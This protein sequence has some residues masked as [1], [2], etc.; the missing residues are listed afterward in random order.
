MKPKTFN[1]KLMINKET[2]SNLDDRSMNAVLG[3]NKTGLTCP[4]KGCTLSCEDTCI[5]CQNTC[6]VTIC[7][8]E[9][10]C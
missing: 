5:S 8:T 9:C 1:K 4:V 10:G 2:V 7:G 3:G 6:P